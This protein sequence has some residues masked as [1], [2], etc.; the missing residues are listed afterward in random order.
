MFKNVQI[1]FS[2][3]TSLQL[4]WDWDGD[5]Q[6]GVPACS[7]FYCGVPENRLLDEGLFLEG[8]ILSYFNENVVK[9]FSPN[10]REEMAAYHQRNI[11][12]SRLNNFRQ[13]NHFQENRQL[14][15]PEGTESHI[16]L[17]CIFDDNETVFRVVAAG[18]G[19]DIEF[20]EEKANV[21]KKVTGLFGKKS[22]KAITLLCQDSRKKVVS[23]GVGE[24]AIHSVLPEEHTTLYFSEDTDL[25]SIR[26]RYLSSL[27]GK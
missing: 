8:E 25:S 12:T 27:I 16:F 24:K 26:I 10:V 15:I 9:I 4:C 18:S 1:R 14:A 23:Y 11:H 3:D 22:R 13:E 7:V 6:S 5:G 21:M 2:T 17:V 20:K 19:R